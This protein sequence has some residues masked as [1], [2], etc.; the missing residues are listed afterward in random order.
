MVDEHRTS[1]RFCKCEVGICKNMMFRKSPRPYRR[2]DILFSV[3][4]LL[5]C[6][7]NNCGC[8]WNRDVNG[9]SNIYKIAYNAVNNEERPKYLQRSNDW[10][11]QTTTTITTTYPLNLARSK[12]INQVILTNQHLVIISYGTRH[13]FFNYTS[14]SLYANINNKCSDLHWF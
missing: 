10:N 3:H 11:P 7:N 4:G 6:K 9:A 8:Y 1:E 13:T 12:N 14:F 5:R 2:R